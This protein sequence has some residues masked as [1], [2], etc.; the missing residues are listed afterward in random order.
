MMYG[1]DMFETLERLIAEM[2]QQQD[3]NLADQPDIPGDSGVDGFSDRLKAAARLYHDIRAASGV[4]LRIS[5]RLLRGQGLSWDDIADDLGTTA[6]SLFQ[7]L[8]MPRLDGLVV[9]WWCPECEG[10]ITDHGPNRHPA[11]EVG[12]GEGCSRYQPGSGYVYDHGVSAKASFIRRLL[13]CMGR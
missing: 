8:A 9:V 2:V 11:R 6:T 7:E 12:H 10:V 4:K 1:N 3:G 5:V 13:T